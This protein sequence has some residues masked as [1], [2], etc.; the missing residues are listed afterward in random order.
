MDRAR[1]AEQDWAYIGDSPSVVLPNGKFVVGNKL[2]KQIRAAQSK[3]SEVGI[4]TF[5][6]QERFQRR[7][8]LDPVAGRLLSDRGCEECS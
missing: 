2:T 3:D 5:E 8:G 4:V 6:G 1:A 7:G